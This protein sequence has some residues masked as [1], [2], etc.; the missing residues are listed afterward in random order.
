LARRTARFR[1]FVPWL[2]RPHEQRDLNRQVFPFAST[3]RPE[4]HHGLAGGAWRPRLL[5]SALALVQLRPAWAALRDLSRHAVA[6]ALASFTSGQSRRTEQKEKTMT[7]FD[8]ALLISAVA[9]LLA[10]LAKFRGA[11]R[12]KR[13]R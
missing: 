3:F 2:A 7:P 11:V 12:R 8:L 9:R 6:P 10:A 1:A 13:R 5:A 4:R